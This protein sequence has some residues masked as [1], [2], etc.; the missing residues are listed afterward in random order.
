MP[1][2]E[3]THHCLTTV[4]YIVHVNAMFKDSGCCAPLEHFY[5]VFLR[6]SKARIQWM[7]SPSHED[8]DYDYRKTLRDTAAPSV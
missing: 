1:N 2:E 3:S 7:S 5:M 8:S 4:V 6:L